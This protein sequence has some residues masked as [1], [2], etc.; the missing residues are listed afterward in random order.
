MTAVALLLLLWVKMFHISSHQK[1]QLGMMVGYG[2]SMVLLAQSGLVLA[3]NLGLLPSAAITIPFFS[4]G[5]SN[6]VSSYIL[7]GLVLSIYRYKNIL[8]GNPVK[9]MHSA[10]VE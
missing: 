1:N 10:S 5:G 6:M 4:A 3:M 7:T 2:C 8:P 9:R